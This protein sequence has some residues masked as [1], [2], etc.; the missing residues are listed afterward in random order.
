[1][2]NEKIF[3]LSSHFEQL[4]PWSSPSSSPRQASSEACPTL[5]LSDSTILHRLIDGDGF[6]DSAIVNSDA[7]PFSSDVIHVGLM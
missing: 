5:C 1:M 4:P 3:L 7:C 2:Q 6:G